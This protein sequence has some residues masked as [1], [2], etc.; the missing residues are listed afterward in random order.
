MAGLIDAAKDAMLNC[1]TEADMSNM[2]GNGID[3]ASAHTADPTTVGDNEHTDGGA[4]Y[5]REALTWAAASTASVAAVATFPVFDIDGGTSV[6]HIGF[7]SAVT[8]GT[9]YGSAAVTQED[10]GGDGTYT[11]TSATI[12]LT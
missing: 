8:S 9:F 12:S 6:T 5:T 2:T 1:L 10:F 3:F 4:G 11:L 7:W